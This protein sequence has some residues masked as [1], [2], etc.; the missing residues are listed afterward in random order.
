M[1]GVLCAMSDLPDGEDAED[2]IA[3]RLE[4]GVVA[5]L[6]K[7]QKDVREIVNYQ[8][9]RSTSAEIIKI[10]IQLHFWFHTISIEAKLI[11][12]IT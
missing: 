11:I 10:S 4:L 8:H 2:D 3:G 5:Q 9:Q 6:G 7:L 1:Q 12:E